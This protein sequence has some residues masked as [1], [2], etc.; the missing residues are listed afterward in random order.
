M[1]HKK[2]IQS[3]RTGGVSSLISKRVGYSYSITTYE[4][5]DTGNELTDSSKEDQNSDQDI[6]RSYSSNLYPEYGD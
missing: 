6:W 4:L 2:G 5:H 1:H 3:R